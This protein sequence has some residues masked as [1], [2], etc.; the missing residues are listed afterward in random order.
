VLTA[1]AG[2]AVFAAAAGLPE[3]AAAAASTTAIAEPFETRSPFFTDISA[4]RPAAVE[5]T[6]IVALSVSRVMSGASTATLSPAFTSTSMTSTSLKSP[7]SGTT[8]VILSATGAQL[9]SG[10]GLAGSMPNFFR[11]SVTLERSIRPSSASALSAAR[12][13]QRRSTSK[14]R[15]SA[16][17]ESLRP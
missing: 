6:S 9:T 8:T 17:R 16:S 4:M 13:I 11:A 10:S 7:R 12:T 5:G 15:R 1:G 14:W 2:S 3:A